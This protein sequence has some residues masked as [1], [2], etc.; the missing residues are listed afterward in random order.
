MLTVNRSSNYTL[1]ENL[2][3]QVN[4][5]L[6]LTAEGTY[7]ERWVMRTHGPWKYLPNDF[8]YRNYTFCRRKQVQ[9]ERA[10]LLTADLSYGRYGYFYDYKLKDIT[11][12][13][14]DGDRITYYPG[15]RIKQ[16]IQ[17]QVLAQVKVSLLRRPAHP[18]YWHRVPVQ[19]SGI[20]SPH[21]RRHRFRLYARRLCAGRVDCH[22]QPYT[23]CR[24]TRHATQGNRTEPQPQSIRTLQSR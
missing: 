10:Q 16:S 18:Q 2:E 23:D 19:P 22:K 5:K 13:F 7:Y 6:N 12:Y 9:A 3:W 17:Q 21:S 15:Q 11:D 1:S 14:K 4:R 20:A 24:R 8:Y